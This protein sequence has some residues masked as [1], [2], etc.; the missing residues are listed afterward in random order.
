MRKIA[1]SR[2]KMFNVIVHNETRYTNLFKLRLT[3]DV[4]I[5]SCLMIKCTI[6]F[7]TN[8]YDERIIS[9][10]QWLIIY[11]RNQITTPVVLIKLSNWT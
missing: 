3:N 4:L 10:A 5:R 8:I 2:G 9:I 6:Q 7:L 11:K 1:K